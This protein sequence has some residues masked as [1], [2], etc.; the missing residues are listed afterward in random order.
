MK[1]DGGQ[2]KL[3]SQRRLFKERA[4]GGEEESQA[5]LKEE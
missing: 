4:D 2:K 1:G 3:D 5:Y